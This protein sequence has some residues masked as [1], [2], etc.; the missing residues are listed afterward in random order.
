[1]KEHLSIGN[2]IG[3]VFGRLSIERLDQIVKEYAHRI[4]ITKRVYSYI[5]R[6]SRATHLANHLTEQQLKVYLGWAMAS[7]MVAI[8]VHLSGRDMDNRVL[9]LNHNPTAF[10]PSEGF[11]EFLLE[12]YQKWRIRENLNVRKIN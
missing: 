8:Y 5:F 1:L 11:R 10:I 9:E 12:M 4:G 2:E 3:N 6:H 7:K